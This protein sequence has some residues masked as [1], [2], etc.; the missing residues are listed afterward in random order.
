MKHLT[1]ST[2]PSPFS[3]ENWF[4]PLEDAIR[5]RVRAFIEAVVAEE[6]QAALGGRARYQRSGAPKGYRNGHRHRQ[7]VGTFGALTVSLPRVRLL[8]GD[9]GEKE[10]RS[11]TIQAYKRLTKRA[12]AII[13]NTYLAG[14]NTRRV[15]RALAGLFGGKVGKD[16]VSRAWRRFHQV[17]DHLDDAFEAPGAASAHPRDGRR[18]QGD[19]EQIRHQLGQTIFGQELVVRQVDH[20]GPDPRAIPHRA[21]DASGKGGP[22]LPAT[23]PA[24]ATMRPMLHDHQGPGLGQIENLAGT[25]AGGHLRRQSRTTVRAGLGIMIGNRVGF[26]DLAQ[27]LALVALLPARL[28]AR[29]LAQAP[30]APPLLLP[31]RR[32]AQS[33]A[34]RRLAAVGAVQAE[35]ALEFVELPPLADAMDAVHLSVDRFCLLAGVEALAEMMEEDAT[36]VCGARHRRHGDRRGYRWGRT[37]SEIGYH[38]G[39][40]KV[41]RPRVR[42]RA[43]KEV[44]LES[45]QA[46]RD[47]NLLLEWA[48]NLMVLNV[49]TR[50][51]HRAVRLPEGDLAK[52]RGDGT[53]KSAVSRRFVALSRKKMKAWLASDLSELDLLVDRI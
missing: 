23:S 4:D 8:D 44:S 7:L 51:Y 3:G 14:T 48:L 25:M 42:D 50:K 45:W 13:A 12:E 17:A 33:I 46:L 30:G 31:R 47:G 52:A 28:A 9:G 22:G 38:G 20:H 10:W 27:G 53:S 26:G 19:G 40:V 36:T 24:T 41:A 1:A 2:S 49:S 6:A 18:N 21:G 37:H 43:G 16:A 39:K 5:F 15:R 11:Q 35:P 29:L 34:G 32:L